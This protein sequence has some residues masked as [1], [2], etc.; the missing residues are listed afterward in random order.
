MSRVWSQWLPFRLE[1]SSKGL[2]HY[3]I[4][5]LSC[6]LD[7]PH[8]TH[9]SMWIWGRQ[10]FDRDLLLCKFL[11]YLVLAWSRP[12]QSIFR[13][14]AD[15]LPSPCTD[16][17]ASDKAASRHW[18]CRYNLTFLMCSDCAFSNWALSCAKD[19]LRIRA[20]NSAHCWHLDG[21]IA[22]WN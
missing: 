10:R 20:V 8:T 19:T 7:A 1:T 17:D 12:S 16:V 6:C 3:F 22:G 9:D 21:L 11:G 4:Y 18:I 15:R 13:I 5:V 2:H 14:P